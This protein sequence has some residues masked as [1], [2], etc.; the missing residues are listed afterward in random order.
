M[1][2]RTFTAAEASALCAAA[3]ARIEYFC[4]TQLITPA[5]EASRRGVSR[6]Y[7][8]E[9]LIEIAVAGELQDAGIDVWM[10]HKALDELRKHW[11]KLRNERRREG[12]AVL[13]LLRSAADHVVAKAPSLMVQIGTTDLLT[14]AI[15][16][17]Y[18]IHVAIPVAWMI[19]QLED[20]T[21]ER[22]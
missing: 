10:I 13:A 1:Q 7:S 5:V 18:A 8:F 3:P 11:P 4:R 16:V 20:T 17:G 19:K 14:T 12:L 22:L 6:R 2:T 9:N 15:S 21:G